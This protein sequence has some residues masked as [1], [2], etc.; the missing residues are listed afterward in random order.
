MMRADILTSEGHYFDFLLP[1]LSTVD[2]ND[3]ATGLSQ[4]C[5][6]N[7]QCSPFYSVAQHSLLVSLMVPAEHALVALLHDA[8]EAYVGDVTAPLKQLLPEYKTIE[9]RVHNAIFKHFGLNPELPP[10][11]KQA[12]L[13]M[14]ATEQRD[15]MPPHADEWAL[16]AG[17][18]PSAIKIS[19]MSAE[20]ARGMF[21]NR[22]RK[23]YDYELVK[24]SQGIQLP[25]AGVVPH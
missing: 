22:F 10:C 23:L 18:T 17:V 1:E 24:G 11:V 8:A 19:P 5:R 16:I 9:A 7:G 15:L 14:L 20:A 6:F 13:K 12:D 21:L 25:A 2:I 4:L 3:I